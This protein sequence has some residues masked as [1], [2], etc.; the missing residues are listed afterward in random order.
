MVSLAGIEQ[1]AGNNE[2]AIDWLKRAYD[3]ATGP[4][5]RFQW[6]TYYVS[7]LLEMTPDNVERIQAETVTVV[8]ELEKGR[9][10][11]QRPK[12]QL[13]RLEKKLVAW[14]DGPE[15]EAGLAYIRKNVQSI[16][17]TIPADEPAR[18]TCE[19][20]LAPA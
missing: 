5:T 18:A 3:A 20:F 13:Q 16:C 7:G 12:G 14:G 11:Y 17:V 4:A 1:E 6:G 9:A 8:R 10:F 19:G 15:R 2:A